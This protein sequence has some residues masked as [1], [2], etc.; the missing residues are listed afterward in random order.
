[1]STTTFAYR[2][3]DADGRPARGTLS[4][5]SRTAALDEVLRRG[6]TPVAVDERVESPGLVGRGRRVSAS[7]TDAFTRQLANLIAAGVPLGRSLQIIARESSSAAE[8]TQRE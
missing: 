3:I 6:L 8:K 1:M 2:A 4:A 5:E 7:A